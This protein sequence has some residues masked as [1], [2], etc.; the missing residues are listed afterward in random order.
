MMCHGWGA[1]SLKNGRLWATELLRMTDG[2]NMCVHMLRMMRLRMLL[3]LL[4]TVVEVGNVDAMV[5][6]GCGFRG[7]F[8]RFVRGLCCRLEVNFSKMKFN[9]IAPRNDF[10]GQ[11]S[12][13]YQVYRT[14]PRSEAHCIIHRNK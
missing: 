9:L 2:Y 8:I 13:L 12:F 4:M 5:S 6:A 1:G 14:Y 3:K 11:K 10:Q 7:S